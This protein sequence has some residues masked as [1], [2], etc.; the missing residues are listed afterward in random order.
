[1]HAARTKDNIANA[2]AS[3]NPLELAALQFRIR[4]RKAIV[5]TNDANAA[6]AE[7]NA[8]ISCEGSPGGGIARIAFMF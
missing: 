7:I 1:M 5:M 2:R 3:L 6:M 4:K 8:S